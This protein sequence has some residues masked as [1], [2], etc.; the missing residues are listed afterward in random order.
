MNILIELFDSCQLE[1]IAS[2]LRFNPKRVVFIGFA[3]EDFSEKYSAIKAVIKEK[4][5][6]TKTEFILVRRHD[7]KSITK[8]LES[9]ITANTGCYLDLTGGKELVLAAMGALGAVHSL[10]M[11]QIDIDTDKIIPVQNFNTLPKEEKNRLSLSDSVTLNCGVLDNRENPEADRA[12]KETVSALWQIAKS[13]RSAWKSQTAALVRFEKKYCTRSVNTFS[14]SEADFNSESEKF[15][16]LFNE[17]KKAGYISS[18][19]RGNTLFYEYKNS[20]IRPYLEKSGSILESYTYML[21][22]AVEAASQGKLHDTSMQVTVRWLDGKK[23][24]S[25]TNE[26]D[27][28]CMD[29]ALPVFISCKNGLFD[30]NALYELDTVADRLGGKYTKKIIVCTEI[31][32][33]PLSKKAV[34]DRAEEMNISIIYDVSKMTDEEITDELKRLLL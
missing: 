24:S 2:F 13:D 20:R 27:V 9:I 34:L 30:K 25:V 17:L 18:S 15:L 14:C 29:G 19:N 22:K 7:Y 28:A 21:L 12:F 10:P 16:W 3:E 8:K 11:Y 5:P 31:S 26:I 6:N 1:N 32:R 23:A 4:S 33:N